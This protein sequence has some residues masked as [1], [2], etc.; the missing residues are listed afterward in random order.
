M[1]RTLS[2][3]F[4]RD[5]SRDRQQGSIHYEGYQILWPDGA[6]VALGVEGF[7]RQG[8]RLLG[9]GRYLAGCRERLIDLLCFP[10]ASRNDDM[11]RLPGHRVRR[12][13]LER[14]GQ[15]GRIHFL[16]GTPTDAIFNLDRDEPHVLNWLGLPTLPDGDQL[17]IDL[18]A[19]APEPVPTHQPRIIVHRHQIPVDREWAEGWK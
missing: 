17:W 18:A 16:D 10:L 3:L 1:P 9:L 19:R 15:Q 4:R 14:T 8:Q 5:P 13:A 12:F 2:L 7:C 6:P 11:T